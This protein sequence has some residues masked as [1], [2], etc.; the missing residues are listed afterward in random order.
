VCGQELEEVLTK[1][2]PRSSR[3]A[4]V[5]AAVL[6]LLL[7]G[8][9]VS[10]NWIKLPSNVSAANRLAGTN[11]ILRLSGS[12]TIGDGLVPALA[13]SFLKSRG[14]T[15]VHT[16]AG[17]KAQEKIVLGTLPG[18]KLPSVIRIAAHGS[19]T[20]FTS[21]ADGSCDIGMASRRIKPDESSKLF[22]LGDM[23]SP[24]SEHIVGLDGIAVIVNASNPVN[25]LS[26]DEIMRV[27]TGESA[28]WPKGS[29]SG[30]IKIY[31]R[32]DKSGTFDTFKALVLAGKPLAPSAQRFESS[33]ELS[34]AV[35]RDPNGIGFI[36]LPFVRSAKAVAV[37]EKGTRAL[38]PT[39]LT[40]ATEDYSLSRR[41]Y[42]YTPTTPANSFTRLFVDFA[43]SKQ[44]QDLVASN[45]FIAQNI[46]TVA[47]A[48]SDSAPAEYKRLTRNA[49]RLSLNFRF[50]AGE[51][52]QDNKAQVDMDRVVSLISERGAAG[53]KI[54]LF[55]FADSVGSPAVNQALSSDRARLIESELVRR[56][57]KPAVVRGFGSELPVASNETADGREKNRRV[58]IWIEN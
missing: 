49:Q 3:P 30:Q 37:S 48:V 1:A 43:L 29:T 38:L 33:E 11:T 16:V 56:G 4:L 45:G 5:A 7:G 40:V 44:G 42:L 39:S 8:L 18:D 25:E 36:G 51:S 6:L 50:Q 46:A 27:F 53:G 21:L 26:K 31:A 32:D 52:M 55:G 10:K 54:L 20:A 23:L 13:E 14:A 15:D 47:Q 22:S 17:E 58:E 9:A 34:D 12:N 41:L 28:N 2:R 35:A 19:A 57:L 24:A